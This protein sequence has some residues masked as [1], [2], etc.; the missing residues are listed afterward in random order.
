MRLHQ[1]IGTLQLLQ[2]HYVTLKSK[3]LSRGAACD[4]HSSA[5]LRGRQVPPP[6]AA[7]QACRRL[8]LQ[9]GALRLQPAHSLVQL[10]RLPAPTSTARCQDLL[11]SIGLL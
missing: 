11:V 1:A 6:V 9:A 10:G 8:A 3:I 2:K 4:V 5:I 7:R